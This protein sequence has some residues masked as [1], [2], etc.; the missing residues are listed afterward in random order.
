MAIFLSLLCCAVLLEHD[1]TKKKL[2]S[3]SFS[4]SNFGNLL[5][6]YSYRIPYSCIPYS[7]SY[8]TRGCRS[9]DKTLLVRNRGKLCEKILGVRI[10]SHRE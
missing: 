3:R 8:P 6:L 7:I 10:E 5:Q 4:Q 9:V 2:G 1:L